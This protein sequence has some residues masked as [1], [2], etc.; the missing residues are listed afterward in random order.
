MRISFFAPVALF[1]AAFSF[2]PARADNA[3]NLQ[4]LA[5]DINKTCLRE[6]GLTFSADLQGAI[7]FARSETT[8]EANL[9]SDNISDFVSK[10]LTPFVNNAEVSRC[11]TARLPNV[12]RV[13]AGEA[14]AGEREFS[15]A[16][17]MA[18]K[19][20]PK[21]RRTRNRRRERQKKRH[22]RRQ[23]AQE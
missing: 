18:L 7:K 9:L 12:K 10:K 14:N 11:I 3:A 8:L 17:G 6:T 5:A 13:M 2:S 4:K 15:L 19:R 22:G 16:P 23:I 21:Q 1:L 20:K